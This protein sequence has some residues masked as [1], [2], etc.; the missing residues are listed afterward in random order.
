[1][2]DCDVDAADLHL[3]L[4]PRLELREPFE[5]VVLTSEEISEYVSSELGEVDM[6]ASQVRAAELLLKRTWPVPKAPAPE[7]TLRTLRV[8][9]VSNP[10]A[11][12]IEAVTQDQLTLPNR[13]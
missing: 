11:E 12:L 3:V 4:Q 1:M 10:V 6:T 8:D 13:R 5:T 2:A 7:E 9:L